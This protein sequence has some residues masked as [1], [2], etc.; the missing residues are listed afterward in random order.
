[1]CENKVL[2]KYLLFCIPGKDKMF[3]IIDFFFKASCVDLAADRELVVLRFYHLMLQ[4]VK[5]SVN[6]A[7]TP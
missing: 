2:C 7:I 5:G 4:S 1:M 3:L 6:A